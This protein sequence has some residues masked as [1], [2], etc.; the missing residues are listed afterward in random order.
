MWLVIA[1]VD[2]HQHT[3]YPV[4]YEEARTVNIFTEQLKQG[5]VG[6]MH[7]IRPSP[8]TYKQGG[9]R[10]ITLLRHRV[11]QLLQAF[12]RT[13]VQQYLASY[14]YY[15]QTDTPLP[16]VSFDQPHPSSLRDLV[17]R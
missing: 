11:A 14:L 13:P 5:R 6:K 1:E 8:D 2:E 15:D 12:Q 7:V 10:A 4:L 3:H 16:D 17:S 9:Q